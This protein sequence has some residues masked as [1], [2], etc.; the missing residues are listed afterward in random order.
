M[1]QPPPPDR[2]YARG[3]KNPLWEIRIFWTVLAAMIAAIFAI[4][5]WLALHPTVVE[6]PPGSAY[7]ARMGVCVPGVSLPIIR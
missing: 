4:F 3:P 2:D 1:P 5:G 6:C 7:V